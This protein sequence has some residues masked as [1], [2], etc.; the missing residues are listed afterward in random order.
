MIMFW[1]C[2]ETD[3]KAFILVCNHYFWENQHAMLIITKTRIEPGMLCKK[4]NQLGFDGYEYSDNKGFVGEIAMGW[5][6]R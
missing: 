3:N 4:L 6:K 5:K 1:N 2:R